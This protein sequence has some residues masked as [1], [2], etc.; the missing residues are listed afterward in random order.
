MSTWTTSRSPFSPTLTL[1]DVLN[2]ILA[3]DA[4]PP[5]RRQNIAWALRTIA[6]VI[7]KPLDELPAHPG[8]LHERLAA[9]SPAIAGMPRG[10]WANVKSLTRVALTKANLS[11]MPGCYREELAADWETMFRQLPTPHARRGLSR[12]CHYCSK[13]GGTMPEQVD[14]RIFA[15][16]L[17][18]LLNAGLVDAPRKIHRTACILWNQAAITIVDW[19]KLQVAVPNYSRTYALPWE[20][21]PVSLRLEYDTYFKHLGGGGLLEGRAFTPLRPSSIAIRGRQLHEFASAAVHGGRDP[22]ALRSFV[23]LVDVNVVKA[24]LGFI[25]GR[26]NAGRDS[27][28]PEKSSVQAHHMAQ[29]LTSIGRHWVKV[30]EAHLARLKAL[31][32]LTDI[33][34]HGL[35]DKNRVLLRQFDDPAAVDNLMCLPE[36][37]VA[38]L[39]RAKTISRAAALQMQV[40]VAIELLLMSPIRISNLAGLNMDTHLI[41]YRKIGIRLSIRGREVKNGWNIE[42]LLA[43][44]TVELI[45]LYLMKFRPLLNDVPTPWLFPGE[46]GKPKS[47]YMLRRQIQGCIRQRLGLQMNPHFFRHFA[48]DHYLKAHPG[49]YGVVRLLLGHK[50]I[51]TTMKYYCD[52]DTVQAGQIFNEHV[53]RIC[54]AR[55]RDGQNTGADEG[56]P[57]VKGR[58]QG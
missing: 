35:S 14:H 6:R 7:G 49:A 54:A 55:R 13:Q 43:P 26:A 29:L 10:R 24:A 38:E 30:D 18:D 45:D 50:S 4:L 34:Q 21:F 2:R 25:L 1:V 41:R 39:K 19:P 36:D 52:S 9:S 32:S 28:D 11:P 33:H 48:G 20:T 37:I 3:D 44:E 51:N 57:R 47:T 5:R 17:D 53:L 42:A 40:A 58:G 15:A 56:T 27:G 16:F 12:F 22:A 46:N 8:R 31:C 23:E